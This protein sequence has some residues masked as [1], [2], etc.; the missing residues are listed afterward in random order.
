[1][2]ISKEEVARVAHLAR[3]EIGESDLQRFAG[4]LTDILQYMD[5][6]N[7]VNTSGIEPLYSPGEH[8]TPYREDEVHGESSREDVL[9][10]APDSDGEYFIVPKVV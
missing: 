2:T 4:Q 1:M 6:L 3:L 10:N 7:E 9:R 5:I 8:D